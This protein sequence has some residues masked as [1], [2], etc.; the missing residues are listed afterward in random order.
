MPAFAILA[1]SGAGDLNLSCVDRHYLDAKPMKKEIE[2]AANRGTVTALQHH[3]SFQSIWGGDQASSVLLNDFEEISPLG[4]T[5]K[6][7]NKGG[8]VDHHQCGSPCES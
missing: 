4:F 5:K 8:S 6:N 7:G 3:G 2:F 1:P